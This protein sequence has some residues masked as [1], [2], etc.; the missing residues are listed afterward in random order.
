MFCVEKEGSRK[1]GGMVP[2]YRLL[3]HGACDNVFWPTGFW[4]TGRAHSPQPESAAAVA[5]PRSPDK[6]LGS[7]WQT[8]DRLNSQDCI[9]SPFF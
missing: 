4:P 9:T 3:R 6:A 8:K 1:D 5:P 7:I 2:L